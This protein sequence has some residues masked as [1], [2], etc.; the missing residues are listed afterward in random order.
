VRISRLSRIARRP[1]RGHGRGLSP[2]TAGM[3]TSFG[4]R[5]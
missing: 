3:D 5:V 1:Y 4:T 2:D